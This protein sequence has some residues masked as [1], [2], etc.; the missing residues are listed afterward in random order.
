MDLF[1]LKFDVFP[2]ILDRKAKPSCKLLYVTPERVSGN[3][4]FYDALRCMHQQVSLYI[5]VCSRKFLNKR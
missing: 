3:A 5:C 1:T 4:S 2:L